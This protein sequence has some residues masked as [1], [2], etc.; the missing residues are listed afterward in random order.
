MRKSRER[1]LPLGD[2]LERAG[3][4]VHLGSEGSVDE[5]A[6]SFA[7]VRREGHR[8]L[9]KR[10]YSAVSGALALCVDPHAAEEWQ[11]VI[12]RRALDLQ[13]RGEALSAPR[14]IFSATI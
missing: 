8:V 14:G 4:E 1:Q 7:H 3:E 5:Q 13:L 11:R 12:A 10:R 9:V 6:L 2:S